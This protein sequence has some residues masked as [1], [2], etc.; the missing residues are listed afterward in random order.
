MP[1]FWRSG[2]RPWP[3]RS[4]V[5]EERKGL[6]EKKIM[7]AKKPLVMQRVASVQ[8]KG[9]VDCRRCWRR[10]RQEKRERKK[11]QRRRLPCWPAQKAVIL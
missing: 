3:S 5:G 8:A 4:G 10:V 7:A 1:M 11:A 6:A 2:F 9:G